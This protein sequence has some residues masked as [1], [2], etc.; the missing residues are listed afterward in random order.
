ME[1]LK[2]FT[3]TTGGVA[4]LV[5]AILCLNIIASRLFVRIDATSDKVFSLSDG[6]RN[7]LGKLDD[8]V[9][10]KL[11]FSRSIKD[12]PVAIKTYAT[13]V[14]EVLNEYAAHSK[15]RLSVEVIDPKPDT[16][17][18]EWAAKYGING[19]RL[20]KG[21]QLFF[22]IVFVAGNREITI[23]YLDPRREVMGTSL[24]GSSMT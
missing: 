15:G 20:P 21:D 24:G 23:P 7:I 18:E 17:E 13:R 3:T 11:Y 5:V 6:T 14:E 10:A 1:K 9:T 2:T 8:D 22:G 4:L 19:V 16:D 12:L